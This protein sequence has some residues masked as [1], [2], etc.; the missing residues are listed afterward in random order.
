MDIMV[1][2]NLF[3]FNYLAAFFESF[4]VYTNVE[5]E[6]FYHQHHQMLYTTNNKEPRPKRQKEVVEYPWMVLAGNLDAPIISPRRI[7]ACCCMNLST[8]SCPK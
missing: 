3:N 5:K 7:L 1:T 2:I 6:N 4:V 8:D